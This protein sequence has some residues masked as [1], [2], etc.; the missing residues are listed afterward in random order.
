[1]HIEFCDNRTTTL[2]ETEVLTG[3]RALGVPGICLFIIFIYLYLGGLGQKCGPTS[4]S[5]VSSS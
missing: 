3:M 5:L 4:D 2:T 1:M